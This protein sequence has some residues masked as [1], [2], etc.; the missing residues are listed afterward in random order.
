[1]GMFFFLSICAG[2]L[3]PGKEFNNQRFIN[4][5]SFSTVGTSNHTSS[6]MC[7]ENVNERFIV[8]SPPVRTKLVP[9]T[10][11]QKIIREKLS[12]KSK[13]LDLTP[14]AVQSRKSLENHSETVHEFDVEQ[15]FTKNSEVITNKDESKQDVDQIS[16]ES[17]V[18]QKSAHLPVTRPQITPTQRSRPYSH[19]KKQPAPVKGR[20]YS[21]T[22]TDIQRKSLLFLQN[23]SSSSISPEK[24]E[25]IYD[26][27]FRLKDIRKSSE[28][29]VSRSPLEKAFIR[30]YDDLLQSLKLAIKYEAKC[31]NF[32]SIESKLKAL[33][34]E[35]HCFR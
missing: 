26:I 22:D 29:L 19:T 24:K 6:D 12:G 14:S 30:R 20:Q 13:N 18:Q 7:V 32:T 9:E 15:F 10:K 28:K 34:E 23:I 33:E 5:I 3:E 27:F 4:L 35:I 11:Q 16:E 25:K 17:H 31:H 8:R 1:M 2:A 21:S